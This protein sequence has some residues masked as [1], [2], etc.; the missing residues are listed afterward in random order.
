VSFHRSPHRLLV[1]TIHDVAPRWLAEVQA[2]R[3]ALV[4]W[5]VDRVTLLAVP[6]FHHGTRLVDHAATVT[7]LRDC[8]SAGDEIALHGYYHLQA[9]APEPL[10]DRLRARLWTA[11]EGE[12]LR[13]SGELATMIERGRDQLASCLPN[14]V[15]FVAPAWLEPRHLPGL[16]Q[17]LGFAWHETSRFVEALAP[18][19]RITAPVI[20]FAT[21][22]VLREALS[23]AWARAVLRLARVHAPVVR[24]AI[25]PAD[26]RSS[27]VMHEL[28]RAVRATAQAGQAVTTSELLAAG[29]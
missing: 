8:A 28:E 29:R 14:P 26:L 9:G 24:I 22:T 15:G 25:H 19:R 17:R 11:G 20:G 21:R 2:L 13:P 4:R 1:A 7:W 5:G 6:H 3:R 12:C 16:L 27:R 10:L 23:I 18:R